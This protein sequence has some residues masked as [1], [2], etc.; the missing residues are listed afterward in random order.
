MSTGWSAPVDWEESSVL[1]RGP[2]PSCDGGKPSTCSDRARAR[3]RPRAAEAANLD[4]NKSS[5][6]NTDGCEC[7]TPGAISATCCGSTCPTQHVTGWPTGLTGANQTFYDCNASLN[8][9]V[10]LEACAAYTGNM[11]YCQTS[12]MFQGR[13]CTGADGGRTDDL[14]VCNF[15]AP[16]AQSC[17]CWT[18][19]GTH[20]GWAYDGMSNQC[21]CPSGTAGDN[22]FH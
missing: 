13:P 2:S 17:V 7:A 18:Y 5:A 4:C 15:L 9:Q 11:S 21:Y 8:A 19:Q 1:V 6:P 10:A 3:S 16:L 14:T 22:A 20:A 12:V